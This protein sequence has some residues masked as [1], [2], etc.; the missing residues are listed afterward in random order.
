DLPSETACP[1][2]GRLYPQGTSF[3]SI[4]G[5]AIFKLCERCEKRG[6]A[7]ANFCA[8]CGGK[9]VGHEVLAQRKEAARQEF[10]RKDRKKRKFHHLLLV[11]IAVAVAIFFCGPWV[12]LYWMDS[13][14]Y[15]GSDSAPSV[16]SLRLSQAQNEATEQAETAQRTAAFEDIEVRVGEITDREYFD[17]EYTEECRVLF[18]VFVKNNG[19]VAHRV[20]LWYKTGDYGG[21]EGY[22]TL[23][24]APSEEAQFDVWY[25][26]F[27]GTSGRG[28]RA[29]VESWNFTIS[30]ESVDEMLRADTSWSS[31]PAD[32]TIPMADDALL[33][34]Y[35][36][37]ER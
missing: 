32:W 8:H 1:R 33:S 24:L 7:D 31:R 29:C 11:L 14:G 28:E 2:C 34:E 35:R 6:S 12:G 3:C 36:V 30:L 20:L 21:Y 9:S 15:L 5:Q 13:K 18:P 23:T 16:S 26:S 27:R 4:D 19:R 17:G 37:V 25:T 10:L 22:E